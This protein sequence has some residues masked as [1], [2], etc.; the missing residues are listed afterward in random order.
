MIR[1][2]DYLPI[3]GWMLEIDLTDKQRMV[4]A[5]IW[6]YSRDGVSRYSGTAK[7]IAEWVGCQERNVKYIIRQ[8]ED[9]GLI[10]HEVCRSMRNTHTEFWAVRPEDAVA[11]ERKEKIDWHGRA[12]DCPTDR[13]N[14]CPTDRAM[15]CPTVDASR[16]SSIS[17]TKYRRG[18]YSAQC[19]RNNDDH[20]DDLFSSMNESGLAPGKG[21]EL[22]FQEDACAHAWRRLLESPVWAAKGRG[23][24]QFILD[25]I[26]E[27]CTLSE[28][29]YCVNMAFRKEWS[30][31]KPVEI[32]ARE[33]PDNIPAI[34]S[35]AERADL[36]QELA[37][38]GTIDEVQAAELDVLNKKLGRA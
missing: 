36:L 8:L 29:V 1:S 37:N 21:L 19:A 5:M 24:L 20:D 34:L 10:G 14:G 17:N 3:Q 16:Y 11:P 26:G 2:D 6:S 13:A 23:T 38:A 30:D 33:N 27:K 32:L 9:L 12:M 18:K 22:P 15:D 28:A 25:E 7:E 31:I 4:Y 35:D